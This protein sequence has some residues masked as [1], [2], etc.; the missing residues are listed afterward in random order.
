M[1]TIDDDRFINRD[2]DIDLLNELQDFSE[3][4]YGD[5]DEDVSLYTS[6]D[7]DSTSQLLF[8]SMTLISTYGTLV[9]TVFLTR[10]L[11]LLVDLFFAQSKNLRNL[12]TIVLGFYQIS[13]YLKVINVPIFTSGWNLTFLIIPVYVIFALFS[14][15]SSKLMSNTAAFTVI[16][17]PIFINEYFIHIEH[18]THHTYLRMILMTLSMKLTSQLLSEKATLGLDTAAYFAHPAS[19]ICGPWHLNNLNQESRISLLVHFKRQIGCAMK[20]LAMSVLI[21]LTSD[22]LLDSLIQH[23]EALEN[24]PLITRMF[25]VYLYAQQFRFS[26]FFISYLSMSFLSLWEDTENRTVVSKPLQVEWPRSLVC[27]VVYWNIPIHKWL[28]D[29]IFHRLRSRTN[30]KPLIIMTTYLV[31][32]IL[33]GFKFH[34]WSVLFSLG[35]FTWVEEKFRRQL[36]SRLDA[37]LLTRECKYSDKICSKGHSRTAHNSYLVKTINFGLR[38]WAIA[39]LAYLGYIFRVNTD[40]S[41]YRDALESWSEM[42]FCFHIAA[43]A[44]WILCLML[45]NKSKLE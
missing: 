43:F 21:L 24:S 35:V 25:L 16:T 27:V 44:Q 1:A 29:Y 3:L 15:R 7:L 37:C 18:Y 10:V 13:N 36:S 6:R 14:R 45:K 32:S 26:H 5:S 23:L 9:L 34:I 41:S 4:D 19:S 22:M 31:S 28:K 2:L 38:L 11:H 12:I 17:L 33:H 30:N 39:Q 20:N 42:Y 40:E 8:Y